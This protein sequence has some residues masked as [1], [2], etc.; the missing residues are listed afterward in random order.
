MQDR[1]LTIRYLAAAYHKCK[2][3]VERIIHD[4][5]H[6]N[7]GSKRKH[8]MLNSNFSNFLKNTAQSQNHSFVM[9]G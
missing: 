8:V 4:R 5:L 2:T 3:S 1:L 7:K 9:S 6:M